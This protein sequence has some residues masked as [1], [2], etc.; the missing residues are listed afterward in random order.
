M[1]NQFRC[2]YC[3]NFSQPGNDHVISRLLFD[4]GPNTFTL[5]EVCSPC[6]V[7][8]GSDLETDLR[9][10]SLEGLFSSMYGVKEPSE[11]I[12]YNRRLEVQADSNLAPVL[13]KAFPFLQSPSH[14]R[15]LTQIVLER[16]SGNRHIFPICRLDVKAKKAIRNTPSDS[17]PYLIVERPEELA[18]AVKVVDELG[19]SIVDDRRIVC[20]SGIQ[21]SDYEFVARGDRLHMRAIA[22]NAFNVFAKTLLMTD[23]ARSLYDSYQ[24]IKKFVRHDYGHSPVQP[25]ELELV[26]T[27]SGAYADGHP[28]H[29][30][31]WR[32]ENG[33]SIARVQFFNLLAYEVE[34][35]AA[36]PV[37]GNHQDVIGYGFVID[38]FR[39]EEPELHAF[40]R[41][42][43]LLAI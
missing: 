36:C 3:G 32:N 30:V 4:P 14:G 2:I 31:C 37:T 25:V 22:K 9:R 43:H 17:I 15:F 20:A 11:V 1:S 39:K 5:D 23:N 35:G 33:R 16:P 12:V 42:G 19:L 21:I 26:S 7:A 8:F 18:D 41:E 13:Q 27:A 24:D 34:L 38:I 29:A 28:T 10:D 40:H 6:N